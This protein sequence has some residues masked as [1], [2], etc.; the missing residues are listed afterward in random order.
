ML[1]VRRRSARLFLSTR[2][3]RPR[4]EYLGSHL[5]AGAGV[6]DDEA[7]FDHFPYHLRQTPPCGV[8]APLSPGKLEV[9][10]ATLAIG[11][12]GGQPCFALPQP[13]GSFTGE[14][15]ICAASIIDGTQS[16]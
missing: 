4:I 13:R 14:A 8:D 10:E 1:A 11:A 5:L 12:S 7:V 15:T 16:H 3:L 2:W 9:V 6:E